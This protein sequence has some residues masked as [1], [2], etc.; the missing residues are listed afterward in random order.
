LK[1]KHVGLRLGVAFAVLI[2]LLAGIGQFGLR[3]MREINDT[4]SSITGDRSDKLQLAREA[5]KFSNRNSL[6]TMEIF[7]VDD[8]ANAGI[9][10]AER[11]EN[12]KRVSALMVKI[13]SRSESEDEKRQLSAVE[14]MRKRY[15]ESYLRAIHLLVDEGKHDAAAAVMVNETIPALF[16]YRAALD[17]FVSFQKGQLDV[18]VKQAEVDYAKA[19]RLGLLLII[20]AM[21]VALVIAVFVT[22]HTAREIAARTDAEKEVSQL[23]AS[24]E[25]RV[26]QRTSELGE[27][28]KILTLQ[29]A[30]LEAAA[31]A[32]VITDHEGNI[33][34]VNRA[35]TTMTGYSKEEALGNNLLKSSKEP[36]SYYADMSSTISSGKV[37][38]G[39]LVNNRKDGS[40]YTEEMT[41]TPVTRD[42]DN[43]ANRYFIA[44]KQDITERKQVEQALRQA[45]EKY[46]AIFESAVVGIFRS[47]PAGRYIDVNPSMAR[48]LGYASPDEMIARITDISRQV[49]VEPKRR[50]ELKRLLEEQ[51]TVKNFECA[52]YRKDGSKMWFS[53]NMRVVSENGVVVG[54]EGTNEDITDRKVAEERVQ[55]LAYYDA[56]TALPN[57]TLLQDRL[58][59]ALADARR[60][61]YK[62]ALLFLDLDRFKDINDSLGHAVGDL[63]LQ[64]VAERLK[65]F[66]REQDTVARL[67]G[68]E[69]LITLTHIKDISDAAVAAE[70]LMDAMIA[71]FVIQGHAVN[72]SCSIGISIF[73]EH[74]ANCEMLIKNADAAMYSAKA[75]GRNNFRFFTEDMNADAVERLTLESGLRSA[76]AQEQLFLMYQPQMDIATGRITGLEALLR[77]QHPELGLVPPDR[78]I[79]IAENSGLIVPIGEWVLRTACSEARK[80]QDDGFSAVTVAVNVSAVQFRQEN[81]GEVIRKVLH[82]TGLPAQRLELELTESLLLANADVTLSV[83]KE[84]KSIGVTLA[85]DDFGTGYSNF[86][87]LRRFQISKLKI[88][89][90]L[91]QD[92][93][94]NPDDAAITA[95]IISMAKSLYLKVIAEGVENEA[96]MAFLRAHQCDE[97]QGYYFSKPLTV[98]KVAD[99]LRGDHSAAKAS[100]QASGAQS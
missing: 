53:A 50:E 70:R 55:Y 100:A 20:L 47:T 69:F 92:I 65:R 18:A 73:P 83:L 40:S 16:K 41:I 7:L 36:Q 52:V 21:A 63:F 5:L 39:E 42:L 14:G 80:W 78:F 27:A 30:A 71:E 57:R 97:I 9:L 46:R 23:N 6:I 87:Y 89:R 75:D 45:E 3:R 85:I 26:T 2:A 64:E 17:G 77:W 66:A 82:E 32:I 35:F 96:Q 44:I 79:R 62:I 67:G 86:S 98:D 43:P 95:A 12:T 33:V 58:T 15:I 51:T 29:T 10:L 81:F 59:K 28:N 72:I 56:L 19:R 88:D 90:S 76:L 38:H 13:A 37:W 34:S 22:R 93:G 54:Y 60:Q 91:I 74:G 61:K 84:L 24:L 4:L 94:V 31:N 68:D 8:R 99:K 48:M 25:E 49:Y 11:S 1:N